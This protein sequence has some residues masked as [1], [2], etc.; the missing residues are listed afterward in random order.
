MQSAGDAAADTDAVYKQT[1]AQTHTSTRARFG[2]F[3]LELQHADIIRYRVGA[4]P[5]LTPDEG[6]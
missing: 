4:A 2:L 1:R 3:V 6:D 5:L